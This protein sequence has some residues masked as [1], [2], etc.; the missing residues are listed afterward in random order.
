[1]TS[2]YLDRRLRSLE[3]YAVELRDW[4]AASAPGSASHT[5]LAQRLRLVEA[6]LAARHPTET[7]DGR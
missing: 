2:P 6:E 7:D 4:L 5:E 1:M 3:E